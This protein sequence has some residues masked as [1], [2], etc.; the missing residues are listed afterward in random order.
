MACQLHGKFETAPDAEFVERA[1]PLILDDLLAGADDLPNLAVGQ[2]FPDPFQTRMATGICFGGQASQGI[3][4][5][6]PLSR[7]SQSPV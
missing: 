6:P 5:A 3:M 2:S 7:I 4:I 1:A